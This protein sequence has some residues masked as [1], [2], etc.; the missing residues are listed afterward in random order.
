MFSARNRST[1]IARNGDIS[2]K[3]HAV[4]EAKQHTGEPAG[5]E[6]LRRHASRLATAARA[7][8][9]YKICFALRNRPHDRR[10]KIGNVAPVAVKKTDD[11]G[12]AAHRP[13]PRGA[14]AAITAM[15]LVH[16][17]STG[18]GRSFGGFVG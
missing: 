17:A 8:A 15:R 4:T 10:Q 18:G 1:A 6:L 5:N 3:S 7:R 12:I 16:D 14:G 2:V 9:H 11:I 13:Q